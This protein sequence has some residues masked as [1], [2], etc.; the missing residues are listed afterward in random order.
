MS[1]E[2][3]NLFPALR[4]RMADWWYY[5][6]TMTFADVVLWV[7][8]ADEIQER[9]EL[10]SWIQRELKDERLKQ[11]AGYLRTQNEHFFN[12]IVVGIYH[13]EPQWLP[14]EVGENPTHPKLVP[15]DRERTAFGLLHLSGAEEIFAIDGQHRVE[16]IKEALKSDGKL[17]G[18]ELCV[19]FVGHRV[20]D[21]GHRR[22]RRLFFTLNR[23]AKP[24]SQSDLIALSEDDAFAIATRRLVDDYPGLDEK[25]VIKA[26]GANLPTGDSSSLTTLVALYRSVV[27]LAQ[28]DK[29]NERKRFSQGPLEA[30][31]ADQVFGVAKRF[32]D[33]LKKNVPPIQEV[34]SARDPARITRKYRTDE[35]GHLLFRPLG[36]RCFSEATQVLVDRGSS[37]EDAVT[38][39]AEIQLN[40]D[41]Y[42]WVNVL[43]NPHTKR[44]GETKNAKLARNLFLHLV[45]AKPDP[46]NFNTL[47][48][49]REV[50]GQPK[51]GLPR[52][53]GKSH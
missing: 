7:K 18:E 5:I 12:A 53:N 2:S 3:S 24:V 43:W 38:R 28:P 48:K 11:I 35:G 1:T 37:I 23:Y 36:L 46:K 52:H 40:L 32:W 4:A 16:G 9:K 26:S 42:P 50:I 45:R 25:R 39:L 33:A 21:T 14:V 51:A 19:I 34:C 6:T 22:T 15:G 20:D 47:Q 27:I 31:D 30:G 10:K 49:Y 29:A 8:R 17:A 41:K 13:G 44:M